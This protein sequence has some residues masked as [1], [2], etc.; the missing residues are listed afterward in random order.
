[1]N[2]PRTLAF[3]AALAAAAGVAAV[4][5]G[6]SEHAPVAVYWMSVSTTS[7][8]GGMGGGQRPNMAQMMSGGYNPNAASH[9]LT[10]QL[11][12]QRHPDGDPTAE[13]DPPTG[14]LVG[15]MLP[16]VTP[17]AQP[18]HD[19]APPGP[20]PQYHQPHGKM[21]IFWG[22]G[23]HAGPGQP[24]VI[25]FA[26]MSTEQG[27]A[28]FGQMMHAL[29]VN[30]MQPPSPGRAV[31][32][33]EWPNQQST[34][35][36]PA[37]G[38]LVGEHLVKGDYTPDIHFSLGDD[39]DFMPPFQMTANQRNPSGSASLGWQPMNQARGF[40]AGMF[41]AQGQDQIVM[42]TSSEVQAMAFG[43]PEYLSDGEIARLVASHVLMAPDQTQCTIPQEATQAV[44]RAGFFT[45]S[46]FGGEA[47]F[48]WPERPRPPRPWRVE[49]TVKVRYRS[50]TSGLVGMDMS[51]MTGANPD[52]QQPPQQQR[53]RPRPGI[54]SFIPG[55]GGF[56]P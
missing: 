11:G 53:P 23:E 55:L 51:Q 6:Q 18:V 49:W 32:Y 46:A 22:C 29:A 52:Q 31:T 37:N 41:G 44:G 13:H 21:L 27:A 5:P 9:T 45:L 14:L 35:S 16:L 26:N 40:F 8:M 24:Y 20:P 1:M 28:R 56:I 25:D 47:N 3:G 34:V 33:G 42:W 19:E 38:S 4:A 36:V 39:Q 7:G 10:L 15:P 50:A 2:H 12:A 30:P 54:G 48:A 17:V 43:L